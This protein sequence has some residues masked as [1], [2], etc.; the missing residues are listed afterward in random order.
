MQHSN[1]QLV[2]RVRYASFSALFCGSYSSWIYTQSILA[3]AWVRADVMLLSITGST[4]VRRTASSQ[5]PYLDLEVKCLHLP[6]LPG[7][8]VQRIDRSLAAGP[9]EAG[10][11]PVISWP[12]ATV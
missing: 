8:L 10:F 2:F 9:D 12:S 11:C 6:E 4:P 5:H 1:A 7:L 3:P